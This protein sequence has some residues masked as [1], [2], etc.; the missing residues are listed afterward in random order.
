MNIALWI[1]QFVSG[2]FFI[3]FGALHFVL[4]EGLPAP[5]AWMYDLSPTLHLVSG[6]AEILGGLGLILPAVTR[7]MPQLVPLAAAGLVLV[8]LGAI[9]FHLNRGEYQQLPGNVLWLVV[10]G[11]IAWGRRAHPLSERRAGSA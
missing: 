7:I 8:M 5:M 6:L 10:N 11:F 2:V 3:A 4:P 1:A 9:A